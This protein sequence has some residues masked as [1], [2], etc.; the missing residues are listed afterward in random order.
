MGSQLVAL[1]F[2]TTLP[3][4]A[5]CVPHQLSPPSSLGEPHDLGLTPSIT[6]S[7]SQPFLG[8]ESGQ[9]EGEASSSLTSCWRGR[10]LETVEPYSEAGFIVTRCS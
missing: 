1:V 10:S 6:L 5:H 8:P 7:Q 3:L 9:R 2:P 4:V